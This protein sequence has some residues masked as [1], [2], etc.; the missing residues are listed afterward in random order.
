MQ[1][2]DLAPYCSPHRFK[3]YLNAQHGGTNLNFIMTSPERFDKSVDSY[4]LFY[5]TESESNLKSVTIVADTKEEHHK[6]SLVSYGSGNVKSSAE[7][8]F[9]L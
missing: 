4:E 2:C 1:L 3:L 6:V 5:R 7:S 8:F 9:L